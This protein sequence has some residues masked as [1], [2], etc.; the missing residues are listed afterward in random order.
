MKIKGYSPLLALLLFFSPVAQA[1]QC[2]VKY[3]AKIVI[4]EKLWYGQ[5][6]K[7]RYKTGIVSGR[8]N[9]KSRC[10]KQA[11]KS[12]KDTGWTITYTRLIKTY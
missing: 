10:I 7:I 3:R 8:G 9:S 4:V 12:I 6:N 5:V 11:V 2:D 1:L